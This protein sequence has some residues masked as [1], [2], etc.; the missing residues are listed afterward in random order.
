MNDRWK[1]FDS[2]FSFISI[3]LSRKENVSGSFIFILS[4]SFTL[5][6]INDF[7]MEKHSARF[8]L[9]NIGEILSS[10]VSIETLK[11]IKKK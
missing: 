2:S 8:Q 4:F 1:Q 6:P 9:K 11:Q 7:G 10:Y 5:V 3:P